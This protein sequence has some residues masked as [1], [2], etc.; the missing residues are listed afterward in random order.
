MVDGDGAGGAGHGI[1]QDDVGGAC[2]VEQTET[3]ADVAFPY[4]YGAFAAAAVVDAFEF[5]GI[6]GRDGD[7]FARRQHV[8]D[9]A[10][11][12]FRVAGAAGRAAAGQHGQTDDEQG[13][14]HGTIR[15]G[16]VMHVFPFR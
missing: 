14:Q 11:G 2:T 7:L 4:A 3:V 1:G 15:A 6:G 16:Q 5:Q 12:V 13:K 10:R 8:G 9:A